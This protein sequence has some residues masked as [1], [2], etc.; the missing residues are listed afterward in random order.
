MF[1]PKSVFIMQKV[2]SRRKMNTVRKQK[3]KFKYNLI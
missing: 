1:F 3:M 2:T